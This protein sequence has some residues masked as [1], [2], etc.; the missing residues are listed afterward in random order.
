M[1]NIQG[2]ENLY[3]HTILDAY[4]TKNAIEEFLDK[5]WSNFID[6]YK[7]SKKNQIKAEE[8]IQRYIC[9]LKEENKIIDNFLNDKYHPAWEVLSLKKEFFDLYL[10][11]YSRRIEWF[12]S[13]DRYPFDYNKFFETNILNKI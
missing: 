12:H 13:V 1:D 5:D 8:K 11:K 10:P 9:Y 2:I 6:E 3:L 7:K 4:V